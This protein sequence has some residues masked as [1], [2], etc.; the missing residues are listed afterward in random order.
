MGVAKSGVDT[1]APDRRVRVDADMV[2]RFITSMHS[3]SENTRNAY[4]AALSLAAQIKLPI[5]EDALK[6]FAANLAKRKFA[7][8]TQQL[9]SKN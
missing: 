8:A 4:R 2:H 9:Y 3:A 5:D 6:A 7:K 1:L